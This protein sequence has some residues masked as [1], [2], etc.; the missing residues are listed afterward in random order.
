MRPTYETAAD[1]QNEKR[2]AQKAAATWGECWAVKLPKQYRADF[3]FVDSKEAVLA[4]C[5]VKC[6]T[7]PHDRY[8]TYMLSLAKWMEAERMAESSGLP[9][10]LLVEFTDGVYYLRVKKIDGLTVKMGG[11]TDR[12]DAQDV[13]PTIHIPIKHFKP[14]NS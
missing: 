13:E 6:R 3:A 9:F 10:Y 11:R 4:W 8:P 14:L 7:N 12:G 1:R 5:E 2:V